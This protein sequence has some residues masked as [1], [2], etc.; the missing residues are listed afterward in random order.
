LELS[1]IRQVGIIFPAINQ[2]AKVLQKKQNY[3]TKKKELEEEQ[4]QV[5]LLL[6]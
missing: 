2:A 6:V 5:L 4:W 3:K 1:S